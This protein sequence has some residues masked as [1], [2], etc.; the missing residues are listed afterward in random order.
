[1]DDISIIDLF[2]DAGFVVK[3]VM[4]IL[5]VA[6]TVSWIIIFE[7][8]FFFK[9]INA[10]QILFEEQFWSG[11]DLEKLFDA[12]DQE[13]IGLIGSP[14]I[15]RNAY[16][17]FQRLSESGPLTDLDLEGLNRSMR[18]SIA[19]DEEDMSRHL[20]TLASIGSVSPYIGLFGT[21][22]GIMGSFQGLSDATQATINAVAPGIS[23][24]LVAT[25]LGLFAAIPAVIAYNRYVA[26]SDSFLQSSTIFAEEL[27]SIFYR[28]S[29]K[30]K[31][32]L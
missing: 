2:L 4:I 6:S 5:L 18:V 8:L 23:E 19:R 20:P 3:S 14:S 10:T 13:G 29:L 31:D 12:V 28:E 11:T 26:K 17:E 24:A 22:W 15:F 1:M 7:R 9:R 27:A 30:G 32:D 25:A 21:V 16:K